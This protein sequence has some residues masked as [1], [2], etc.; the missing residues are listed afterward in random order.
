MF[1]LLLFLVHQ[2]S[3]SI[4]TTSDRVILTGASY[5]RPMVAKT[6]D[7]LIFVSFPREPETKIR[8]EPEKIAY[9][10][11]DVPLPAVGKLGWPLSLDTLAN[12]KL[13][14]G[15]LTSESLLSVVIDPDT[16]ESKH[17]LL[18]LHR[19]GIIDYDDD[20]VSSAEPVIVVGEESFDVFL[21]GHMN[22]TAGKACR[23]RYDQ[24]AV[25]VG[26]T[27]FEH[28]LEG[29][30]WDVS[31]VGEKEFSWGYF[32]TSFDEDRTV[33]RLLDQD[34]QVKA[35]KDLPGKAFLHSSE[36]PG[37]LS[38]CRGVS[39]HELECVLLDEE[40]RASASVRLDAQPYRR[41][42]RA[43]RLV[44]LP[45]GGALLFL[46]LQLDGQS[47]FVSYLQRIDPHGRVGRALPFQD[48]VCKDLGRLER[49]TVSRMYD[50]LVCLSL[51]CR[52][53]IRTKCVQT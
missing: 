3:S 36:L 20:G 34:L 23:L 13:V 4:V 25:L 35:E 46:V 48:D 28:V 43:A 27:D 33:V 30:P 18:T 32:V 52:H 14:L 41:H 37:R 49:L 11:C 47:E 1:S 9:R 39:L 40:L 51:S 31:S 50:G 22:C 24:N 16:C 10:P 26:T 5:F 53:S 44:S 45:A 6:Y 15:I 8:L 17:A 7:Q 29:V 19:H 42:L 12:G 21:P 38:S 2:T